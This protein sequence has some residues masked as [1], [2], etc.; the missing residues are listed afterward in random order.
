MAVKR[1]VHCEAVDVVTPSERFL[2]SMPERI[3]L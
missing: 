1:R 2:A 3:M